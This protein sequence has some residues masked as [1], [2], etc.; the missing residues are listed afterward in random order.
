MR[1]A[2]GVVVGAGVLGDRRAARN[3]WLIP[4]RDLFGFAVWLA[5]SFGKPR[6]LAGS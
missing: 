3:F 4:L 5:G 1:I 6:G 2:A